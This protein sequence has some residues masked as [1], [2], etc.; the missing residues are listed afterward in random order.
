MRFV[1]L[2]ERLRRGPDH[3]GL[4]VGAGA[5]AIAVLPAA[6]AAGADAPLL[7]LGATFAAVAASSVAWMVAAAVLGTR[8]S[9]AAAL[10]NE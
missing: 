5:A 2:S 1:S 3:L 8:G 7:E 10:R 9:P 4:G 6:R